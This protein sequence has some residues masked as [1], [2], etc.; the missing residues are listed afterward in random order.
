MNK[1]S[2]VSRV[3]GGIRPCVVTMLRRKFE[4]QIARNGPPPRCSLCGAP[5]CASWMKWSVCDT[6]LV[7]ANG[8]ARVVAFY[9]R[10]FAAWLKEEQG[11]K[12]NGRDGRDGRNGLDGGG[13]VKGDE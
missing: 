8:M 6:C 12:K 11:R 2:G 5:K 7:R 1:S 3:K 13:G 4:R 9:D 10:E